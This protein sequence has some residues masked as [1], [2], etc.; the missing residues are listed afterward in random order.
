MGQSH[1][2]SREPTRRPPGTLS[3]IP[4]LTTQ[5]AS[6]SRRPSADAHSTRACVWMD[7]ETQSGLPGNGRGTR[8]GSP[9]GFPQLYE[10]TQEDQ[11][12]PSAA[13]AGHYRGAA[14]SASLRGGAEAIPGH[15]GLAHGD[16]LLEL[17]G[18]EPSTFKTKTGRPTRI[19]SGHGFAHTSRDVGG[20][21]TQETSTGWSPCLPFLD[22]R[23]SV[24]NGQSPPGGV[25][26]KSQAPNDPRVKAARSS[27][28]KFREGPRNVGEIRWKRSIRSAHR[29]VV[30]VDQWSRTG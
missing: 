3:P 13:L 27:R 28:P 20:L 8:P 9:R 15:E 1:G 14:P 21:D 12:L 30:G 16:A 17:L 6:S 19:S 18:D 26:N 11:G 10:E 5:R 23:A 29:S 7:G 4:G 25:Y 2:V 24:P 22:R